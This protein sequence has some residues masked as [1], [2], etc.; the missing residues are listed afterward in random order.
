MSHKRPSKRSRPSLGEAQGQYSPANEYFQPKRPRVVEHA[1]QEESSVRRSSRAPK[2]KLF[3]DEYLDTYRSSFDD[4]ETRTQKERTLS[5]TAEQ[6]SQVY[7]L[8]SV[9]HDFADS[10]RRKSSRPP[11]PKV[12]NEDFID[13]PRN[14]LDS[15]SAGAK[16][17]ED[18]GSYSDNTKQHSMHKKKDDKKEKQTSKGS[19]KE[20]LVVNHTK[21]SQIAMKGSSKSRKP[22]SKKLSYYAG[23]QLQESTSFF[24]D[25]LS[26]KVVD[27]DESSKVRHS[28]RTPKPK[29]TFALIED[30]SFDDSKDNSD[31]EGATV[32]VIS[33]VSITPKSATKLSKK[34]NIRQGLHSQ[35]SV[36]IFGNTEEM[37]TPSA[38][39]EGKKKESA[40]L[41][42]SAKKSKSKKVKPEAEMVEDSEAL[43]VDIIGVEIER[44]E[45]KKDGK[46]KSKKSSNKS[47]VVSKDKLDIKESS[48]LETDSTKV[49]KKSKKKLEKMESLG[50]KAE[51]P[52]EK[53][54]SKHSSNEHSKKTH[55]KHSKAKHD[56]PHSETEDK[57]KHIILKLHLPHTETT[58]HSHSHKKH[59][60]KHHSSESKTESLSSDGKA[61]KRKLQMDATSY[62]S[63]S[64][65]KH[66][67][68]SIKFKGL[69][70]REP[71]VEVDTEALF[72]PPNT[73][74]T[75]KEPEVKKKKSKKHSHD[76]AT[77]LIPSHEQEHVK[78]IIKKSKKEVKVVEAESKEKQPGKTPAK[79][80]KPKPKETK[81][82][83]KESEQKK[84]K[85]SPKKKS[86]SGGTPG[87]SPNDKEVNWT[88]MS[89]LYSQTCCM[90][91]LMFGKFVFTEEENC[92]RI[93]PVLQEQKVSDCRG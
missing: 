88:F 83:S 55:S 53:T 74:K 39:K 63:A 50:A 56:R 2:P 69:S 30:T 45:K 47:R 28:S 22:G 89:I 70:K 81:V 6:D 23:S 46:E 84:P 9:V 54:S 57:D 12:F 78:V 52:L 26:P 32:N 61:K 79:E 91:E 90:F 58:S 73:G 62:S 27:T 16:S 86:K 65:E 5:P 75:A 20:K 93:S 76:G 14:K 37:Q 49:K 24:G 44:Q 82:V 29:K 18:Y 21:D 60:H 1:E 68:V 33:D 15:K 40:K 80:P 87:K 7:T 77:P 72:T 92:H 41:D 43:V 48:V 36:N 10:S 42:S 3:D 11:K 35:S 38:S 51:G 59:K 34:H 71:D 13:S 67:K 19:Q 31:E 8:S 85:S 25:Q 66:K 17:E 4:N 64:E